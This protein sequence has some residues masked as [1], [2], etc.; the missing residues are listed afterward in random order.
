MPLL[1]HQRISN[2]LDASNDHCPAVRTSASV[3]PQ[4]GITQE[5]AKNAMSW[6][7]GLLNSKSDPHSNGFV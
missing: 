2:K 1:L 6:L 7:M 4:F 3:A 5:A